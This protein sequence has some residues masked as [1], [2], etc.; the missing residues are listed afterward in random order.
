VQLGALRDTAAAA[1][2]MPAVVVFLPWEHM[3]LPSYETKPQQ[4]LAAACAEFGLECVDPL[5]SFREQQRQRLFSDPL[6]FNG[7][8]SQLAAEVIFHAL[9]ERKLMAQ[10]R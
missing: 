9:T 2:R 3:L 1:G 10:Q 4:A 8:G 5:P 6:H 7:P